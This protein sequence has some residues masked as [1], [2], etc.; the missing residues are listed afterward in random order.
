[1]K[2]NGF[3]N[4]PIDFRLLR[5]FNQQVNQPA[6]PVFLFKRGVI[7]LG[8]EN[9]LAEEFVA[10]SNNLS[11]Q[12]D[13]RVAASFIHHLL[14]EKFGAKPDAKPFDT[15]VENATKRSS[16]A[17]ELRDQI[18]DLLRNSSFPNKHW[19]RQFIRF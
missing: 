15:S 10:L 18:I 9:L 3:Q 13:T 17:V 6:Q 1:L 19:W 11:T 12:Y 4:P 16:G 5:V 7:L 8:N 14:Q 2:V